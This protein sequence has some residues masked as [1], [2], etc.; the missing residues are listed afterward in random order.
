[1]SIRNVISYTSLSN[2]L[3]GGSHDGKKLAYDGLAWF[4]N[5]STSVLIVFV[6]KALMDPKKGYGFKFGER[7]LTPDQPA[8]PAQK[9][10]PPAAQS[11]P[12]P[13]GPLSS[14]GTPFSPPASPEPL[15]LASLLIPSSLPPPPLA[16]TTLCAFHF[17]SA[18]AAMTLSQLLG[19]SQRVKL[20]LIGEGGSAAGGGGELEG[21]VGPAGSSETAGSSQSLM[22]QGEVCPS[23]SRTR[24]CRAAAKQQAAVTQW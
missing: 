14:T 6:N 11:T 9:P 20:P 24:C 16:A 23:G 7:P 12:Q 1:M 8:A 13:P 22:R 18:A 5:V 15:L 19:Y 4:L 3:A 2:T 21:A 17:L 10:W